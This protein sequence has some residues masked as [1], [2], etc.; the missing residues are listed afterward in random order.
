MG[1]NC[2]A[3]H[4]HESWL[5]DYIYVI[6][7]VVE[8]L[9]EKLGFCGLDHFSLVLQNMKG[10]SPHRFQFLLDHDRL[11]EVRIVPFCLV[12]LVFAKADCDL[13]SSS[14]HK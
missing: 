6:Q 11:A 8:S 12:S 1:E 13:G 4:T 3:L 9:Q 10:A 2:I 7:E 14:F 5:N